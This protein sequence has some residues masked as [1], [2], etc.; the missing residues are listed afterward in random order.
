MNNKKL[1][2]ALFIP[3]KTPYSET[4]I[5]VHKN[6]LEGHVFCYYG[7]FENIKLENHKPLRTR[8]QGYCLKL[9]SKFFKKE[10][11]SAWSTF[12][13]QSLKKHKIDRILIE[14]GTHAHGLLPVLKASNIPAIVHF[15]GYDASITDVIK[16][17]NAYKQVFL[18]ASKVIAVSRVMEHALLSL[19]CPKDKLIYNVY[20]PRKDFEY[21]VPEY[22]KKQFLSVGRFTDKKAPYY[23]I[24]AFSKVVDKHPS[25]K[26]LMAGDGTLLST[27]KNIVKQLKLENNVIFLG[28][29]NQQ[30]YINLLKESLAFVQHSIVA[31]NGDS[32]GTPLSILEASIA[33]LP[34]ISTYHAGIPDVI[35][36]NKT[37]LLSKEHDLETMGLNMLKLLDDPELAKQLG[38]AG[39]EHVTN[40]FN[41][42]LHIKNLDKILRN[43]TMPNAKIV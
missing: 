42:D 21:V 30:A 7:K 2:T 36:H 13:L 16:K 25:A 15:H 10:T 24:M 18:Y 28:V 29:I 14:Y 39:K 12:V 6:H 32:E 17:C 34:V 19:G 5:Q 1:N 27:C 22:S 31:E 11:H 41:M 3:G 43:A 40:N 35:E 38:Q 37:G 20:G 33:G 26:L 4:F 9:K 8:F 23:T